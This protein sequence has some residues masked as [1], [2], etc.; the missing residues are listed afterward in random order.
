[1]QKLTSNFPIQLFTERFTIFNEQ[2]LYE[3]V[4][5]YNKKKTIYYSIYSC[6]EK[7]DN[8]CNCNQEITDWHFCNTNIDK[9]VFDIDNLNSLNIVK[10]FHSY[11]LKHNLKH[12]ILF[13][14]AKGFHV[15]IFTQTL[16]KLKNPKNTLLNAHNYFINQLNLKVNSNGNS[17]IDSHILGDV[18]RL[19][20]FPNTLHLDSKLYCIP[21]TTEDLILGKSHIM[22]KAQ[23][24]NFIFTFYGKELLEISNFDNNIIKQINMTR[25]EKIVVSIDK[26]K[27]L[28]TLPPCLQN[29]LV[30]PYVY[31]DDRFHPLKYFLDSGYTDNEINLIMQNFLEGKKHPLKQHDNY[32]HYLKENQL[33]Y[34]KN[35]KSLFSC[36][37]I[38]SQNLCPVSGLCDNIKKNPLYLNKN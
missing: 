22:N 38:K 10:K 12:L 28:D 30:Q 15:Y 34:L 14:G 6:D 5:A 8:K 26:Q 19:M 33:Q 11:L 3:V 35:N 36:K 2:E 21:L 25:T 9:I 18:S 1:M 31:W 7:K 13:S 27:I 16:H 17:D 37:K 24:Q 32:L 20:R 23:K 29:I 4:N